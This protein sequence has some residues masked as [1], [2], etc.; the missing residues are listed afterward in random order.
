[1]AD[2]TG[3]IFYTVFEVLSSLVNFVLRKLG[4]PEI[5]VKKLSVIV[6]WILVGIGVIFLIWFTFNFS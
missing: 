3:F 4:Y 6:G 1:M 5:A 2:D